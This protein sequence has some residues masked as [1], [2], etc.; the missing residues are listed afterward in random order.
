M[1]GVDVILFVLYLYEHGEDYP[2]PNK[3]AVCISYLDSVHFLRP[4]KMRTFIYNEILIS[5]PD[6]A[7]EEGFVTAHIW[8]CPPLK[9]DDYIF[10]CKLEDQKTSKDAR[11]RQWYVEMLKEY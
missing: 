1:D 9:G 6:Y 10:Y 8:A 2:M 4:R 3:R 11:L 5:Y 7:R